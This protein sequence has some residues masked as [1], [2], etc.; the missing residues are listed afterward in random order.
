MLEGLAARADRAPLPPPQALNAM[1]CEVHIL[2]GVIEGLRAANALPP[3]EIEQWQAK[4]M[5]IG[6]RFGREWLAARQQADQADEESRRRGPLGVEAERALSTALWTVATTREARSRG[7][8]DE[9]W[10]LRAEGAA[11]AMLTL[12][13]I[14]F[15][16]YVTWGQMFQDADADELPGEQL[17]EVEVD[18]GTLR[19]QRPL[20]VDVS[21][22]AETWQITG[23]E[24]LADAVRVKLAQRQQAGPRRH[25]QPRVALAD[26]IGTQYRPSG[27]R[28]SGGL[29][30][31][32]T[33]QAG[34]KPAPPP[35]ARALLLTIDRHRFRITYSPGT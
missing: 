14:T 3:E 35:N 34:F 6:K 18:L 31:A 11:H 21:L 7:G 9:G 5:A 8:R 2:L 16:D 25:I 23:I 17:D 22:D 4:A 12:K 19:L 32:T 28:S 33:W 24:I 20:T 30:I 13:L 29:D 27:G 1:P 15:E 26:D 10:R